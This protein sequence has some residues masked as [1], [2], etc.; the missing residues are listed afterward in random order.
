MEMEEEEKRKIREFLKKVDKK[1]YRP[2]IKERKSL[3]E[4]MVNAAEEAGGTFLLWRRS[5]PAGRK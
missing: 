1:Y 4:E 5:N 3:S 2:D